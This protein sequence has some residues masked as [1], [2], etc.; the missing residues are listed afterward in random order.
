V[1][2]CQWAYY[3]IHTL[4]GG[5][6]PFIKF[7]AFDTDVQET[8]GSK[9]KL[10][11]SDFFDLFADIDLGLVVRDFKR[12][13]ALHPHL[14]W[15]SDMTLDSALVGRGCQGLSRLGRVVLF[16]LLDTVIRREVIKRFESLHNSDIASQMAAFDPRG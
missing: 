3:L 4:L 12:F 1:L 8:E 13:P 11:A 10:P 5:I 14:H 9:H 7:V 6:P 15:L 16:E 2:I